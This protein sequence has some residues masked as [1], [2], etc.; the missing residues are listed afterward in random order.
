MG[1]ATR[2]LVAASGR[3]RSGSLISVGSGRSVH[4]ALKSGRFGEPVAWGATSCGVNGIARPPVSG[5]VRCGNCA[6]SGSGFPGD[7]PYEAAL[8]AAEAATLSPSWVTKSDVTRYLRCPYAW[9]LQDRGEISFEDTVD[10]FQLQLV[11]AGSEFHVEVEREAIPIELPEEGL[12]GLLDAELTL[13]GTPDFENEELRIRGR[14]DGIET[15]AGAL[16]PIE[17]K[18][19]KDVQATDQLEL[20][21]YWLLLEPYRTRVIDE[22]RGFLELRR[23]GG[24]ERVEVEIS[25]ERL[26][27]ARKLILD[28]R[29]ARVKG[30]RPRVCGCRVCSSLRKDE[31]ARVTERNKDL[32]LL[33]GIGPV[34]AP[35]LERAGITSWEEL[36]EC[37]PR[38]V[39]RRAGGDSC[40]TSRCGRSRAGSAM[41]RAG[42][43]ARRSSSAIS[44]A[45]PSRSSRSTWST[46]ASATARSGSSAP[47]SPTATRASTCRSGP[48]PAAEEEH[49]LRELDRAIAANPELPIVTWSGTGADLP[50]IAGATVGLDLPH[51]RE[52]LHERHIDLFTWVWRSVRFPRP[53]LD[54]KTVAK[55]PRRPTAEPDPRRDGSGDALRPLPRRPQRAEARRA[56]SGALRLQPRRPRL[57]DRSRSA[58]TRAS[59]GECD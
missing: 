11:R 19:H 25:A 59:C 5:G 41:R 54:L 47:A 44:P 17:I 4:L 12:S 15:A 30:V 1:V 14:P 57:A 48:T 21:F 13:L 52:A 27:Q 35:I 49:A 45:S 2:S 32:T 36:L 3:Y 40:S 23:N 22:P 34:Y 42:A 43:A 31:V 10:E 38:E 55:L 33:F 18:S 29:R 37:D 24:H 9:Y 53:G 39:G 46:R 50:R 58:A 16:L 6:R 20:A 28:V 51:L 8:D 56:T 26:K 7:S